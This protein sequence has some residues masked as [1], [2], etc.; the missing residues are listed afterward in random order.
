MGKLWLLLVALGV[1]G[2]WPLFVRGGRATRT[3]VLYA[4]GIAVAYPLLRVIFYHWYAVPVFVVLLYGLVALAAGVG[5]GFGA[6]VRAAWPGWGRHLE[7]AL[8]V[9][10]AAAILAAPLGSEV[11]ASVSVLRKPVNGGRFDAYRRAGLWIRR[12]SLPEDRIGFGEIGNLAYWSRRPVDDLMGLVTPRALPYLAVH[13][14]AGA[15][16]LDPPEFFLLHPQGPLRGIVNYPW[17]KTAYYPVARIAD[18][19]DEEAAMIYRRRPGAELPPPRPP[20]AWTPKGPAE[21]PDRR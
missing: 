2:Q 11:A 7:P 1:A 19:R 13:D 9:V 5:R 12:H 6:A 17:F 14:A 8:A 20:V 18:P 21:A 16:L 3:L 10:L 4:A 15:F